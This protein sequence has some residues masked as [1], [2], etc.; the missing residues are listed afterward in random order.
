VRARGSRGINLLAF[1]ALAAGVLLLLSNF[2]LLSGFNAATLWP[3]LLVIGGVIILFQGDITDAG[4]VRTFGI[5]RGTVESGTLEI[6]AGE[7]D[8]QVHNL[9]REGRLAA[10]Q[11]AFDSRPEL[12]LSD[13][14]ATL[15]MKRSAT[16]WLS[17]G[18]WAVGLARDLPWDVYVST[19]FGQVSADLSD[20]IVRQV[21][22]ATGIGDIRMTAPREAFEPLMLRSAAG[23]LHIY[24]PAGTRAI[25]HVQRSSFVGVHADMSRYAQSEEG[26]YVAR[27]ADFGLEPVEIYLNGT[28]GEI[29]LA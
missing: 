3:L 19:S 2:L 28:F 27:N 1:L 21:V 5:T 17:F 16:P 13:T 6:S 26:D 20:A 25:I 4:Q 22:L 24:T 29:Y 14:H 11:Y 23:D 15:R 12:D 8:V 7:I 9:A 10:G 18:D